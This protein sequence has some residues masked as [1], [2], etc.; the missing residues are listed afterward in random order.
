MSKGKQK[1]TERTA[2]AE[3][4]LGSDQISNSDELKTLLLNIRDKMSD[5]SG[6]PI[7]SLS[8]INHVLCLP[9]IYTLLNDENKELARDIW[10]RLKSSGMQLKSPPILFGD[11]EDRPVA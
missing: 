11:E 3:K 9:N 4:G 1:A 7:Y 8:A 5:G 2:E 10:L 6:A